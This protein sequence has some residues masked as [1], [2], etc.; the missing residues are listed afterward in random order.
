MEYRTENWQSNCDMWMASSEGLK[1]LID[2]FLGRHSQTFAE[3][4]FK[5][6]L[7]PQRI[8]HLLRPAFPEGVYFPEAVSP[9]HHRGCGWQIK[10][11]LTFGWWENPGL[12]NTTQLLRGTPPRRVGRITKQYLCVAQNQVTDVELKS[13]RTGSCKEIC[14]HTTFPLQLLQKAHLGESTFHLEPHTRPPPPPT[15][16][17]DIPNR[18]QP[19]KLPSSRKSNLDKHIFL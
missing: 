14:T 10:Q 18:T 19:V 9:G 15:L 3:T 5:L 7:G 8:N 17:G 4:E 12:P 1:V 11:G 16:C 2:S 6:H 13:S